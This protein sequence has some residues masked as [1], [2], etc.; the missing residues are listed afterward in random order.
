MTD[1]DKLGAV[2]A[3]L[4]KLGAGDGAMADAMK[5]LKSDSMKELRQQVEG[6]TKTL[7]SEFSDVAEGHSLIEVLAS[8]M[9]VLTACVVDLP[10]A[11]AADVLRSAGE[12]LI[13][14]AEAAENGAFPW[15]EED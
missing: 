6:G 14:V 3:A 4:D 13:E 15:D 5:E 8:C 12:G 7:F 11:E 1:K 2:Q 9:T 10:R